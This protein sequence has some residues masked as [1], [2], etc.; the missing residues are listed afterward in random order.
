MGSDRSLV[1][2]RNRPVPRRSVRASAAY[3]VR[4]MGVKCRQARA[5]RRLAGA[6]IVALFPLFYFFLDHLRQILWALDARPLST[7]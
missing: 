5:R 2:T 4:G 3:R 6:A 1:L 7:R